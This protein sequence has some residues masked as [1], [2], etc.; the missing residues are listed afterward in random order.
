MFLLKNKNK[1]YHLISKKK[2]SINLLRKK[3]EK[4]KVHNSVNLEKLIYDFKGSIK[5]IDCNGF[6]DFE[7]L[8]NDIKSKNV[9]PKD[10]EKNPIEFKSKLSRVRVGGDKS[11]KQLSEEEILQSFTNCERRL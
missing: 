10:V 11:D 5:D 1:L 8:L 7:T 6:I 4:L 9:K 3:L 2:S